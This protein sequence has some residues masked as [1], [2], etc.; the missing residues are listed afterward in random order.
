MDS[1]G[2]WK[3]AGHE[4]LS[5]GDVESAC[6]KKGVA[7]RC[8]VYDVWDDNEYDHFGEWRLEHGYWEDGWNDEKN[9]YFTYGHREE[10][11]I[12]E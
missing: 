6:W 2:I 4:Y 11:D 5:L 10:E 12:S 7:F 9:Y 3:Y 1:S 8:D